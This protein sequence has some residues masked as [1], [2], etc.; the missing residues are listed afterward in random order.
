MCEQKLEGGRNQ[1]RVLGMR[2]TAC[3]GMSRAYAR[4]IEPRMKKVM[5]LILLLEKAKSS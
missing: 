3:V 5:D 1:P 4:Q 2:K